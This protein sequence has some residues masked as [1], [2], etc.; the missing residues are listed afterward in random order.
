M[1]L[2]VKQRVSQNR[3]EIVFLAAVLCIGIF[4]YCTN[5]GNIYPWQDEAQDELISYPGL[6][7]IIRQW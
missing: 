5:L 2:G 3:I 7:Q 4:L 6:L 1:D